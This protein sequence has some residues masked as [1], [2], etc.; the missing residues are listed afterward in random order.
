M[1]RQR[2]LRLHLLLATMLLLYWAASLSHLDVAPPVYEDE[3]WQASTGWK[4]ATQGVFGSDVFAGYHDM[5]RRYYGF[6]PI[7]PLLLAGVFRLAG[8][9]L[10]Q[11][12]LEAV[13]MGFIG[14]AL[15]YALGARLF[16]APVGLLAVALLLFTRFTVLSRYQVTGIL[17]ADFTRIARYDAVVPVFGLASLHSYLSASRRS[18]PGW[19]ALAGSLA[20]LAGLSH[21][22]GVFW[23]LVLA[24]LAAWNRAG[25]R[26]LAATAAGFAAVWAPYLWYVAGDVRAWAGQTRQYAPR[27]DLLNPGWY[28]DNLRRE[29]QR[30]QLGL[31]LHKAAGALRPGVWAVL[32]GLLASL[33][34]LGWRAARLQDKAARAVF[35]PALALPVLFALLLQ[36]KLVNYAISL[37]PMAA[38]ALAWG[39][40][41]MWRWSRG[42]RRGAWVRALLAA[43]LVAIGAEGVRQYADFAATA[44][45][46]S[47]Y[48]HF[49][50]Q[51]RQNI[52]AGARVLGL[53]TY[54]FGLSDL[55][56]RSW[57]VPIALAAETG[58]QPAPSVDQALDAIAPDVILVDPR[59]RAFFKEAPGAAANVQPGAVLAWMEDRGYHQVAAVDDPTY[60]QMQIYRRDP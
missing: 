4:L 27:F 52:P 45:R 18:R 46:V 60:G 19:Y 32:I 17:W 13:V 35:V 15:T 59:M 12:R 30:Y 24:V 37:A 26:A 10:F 53:H 49:I 23:L 47:P 8:L 7:H 5:D 58:L 40:V 31:N 14:L 22:Y 51:V 43:W 48:A 39:A 28:L 44:R 6:L 25:W 54:W 20:G 29:P 34:A 36:L 41:S 57:Y 16:D 55:D 38:L 56:Y 3:P 50:A 33:A 1:T 21:L 2:P 9:G 42:V 11:A